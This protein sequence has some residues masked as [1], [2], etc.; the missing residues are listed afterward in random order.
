MTNVA[1]GFRIHIEQVDGYEMRAHFDR[2]NLAALEVDEQPPLGGERGPNPVRLLAASVG[3]CLAA[4]LL[5]CV[6]RA[7]VPLLGLT[8]SV[9]VELVRNEEKR[10]RVGRVVVVLEPRVEDVERF[11]AC[12]DLFED[13]CVVTQSVRQGLD[14]SVL[15]QPIQSTRLP[16]RR[17]LSLE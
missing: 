5:F 17:A 13:F 2:P 15:V 4:S 14:V 12:A 11:S 9:D 6:N 10:L 3:S 1:T 8:A 7:K 16:M